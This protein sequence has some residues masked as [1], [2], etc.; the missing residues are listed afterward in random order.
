VFGRIL[1]RRIPGTRNANRSKWRL[2]KFPAYARESF[3]ALREMEAESFIH[4]LSPDARLLPCIIALLFLESGCFSLVRVSESCCWLFLS[5]DFMC[6][7][8]TRKKALV[9]ATA[10]E[11]APPHP[12]PERSVFIAGW[13]AAGRLLVQDSIGSLF[14][15]QLR[16]LLNLFASMELLASGYLNRSNS[17]LHVCTMHVYIHT[18]PQLLPIGTHPLTP[19]ATCLILEYSSLPHRETGCRKSSLATFLLWKGCSFSNLSNMI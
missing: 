8:L 12:K 1:F 5:F 14:T 15:P 9:L 3:P 10:A 19:V 2:N 4:T 7:Q 13:L 16:T 18:L 17:S 6:C 11:R